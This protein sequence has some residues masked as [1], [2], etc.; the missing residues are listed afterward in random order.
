MFRSC[1][2]HLGRPAFY[3]CSEALKRRRKTVSSGRKAQS[4]VR[5]RIEAIAG[6]QKDS[7][8]CRGL[9]ERAGVLSAHQPGKC[10]HAALGWNPA[11]YVAMVRH[12][13]LQKLEVSGGG[14]LGLAKHDV[15]PADSDFGKNFSGGGIRD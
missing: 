12:K 3:K 15:T 1:C 2:N 9:A 5:G 13:A 8:L 14:F 11:E 7:M 4:E 10:G 6:S